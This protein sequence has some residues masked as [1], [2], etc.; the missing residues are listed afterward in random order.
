MVTLLSPSTWYDDYNY[1]L[2]YLA[3]SE[4]EWRNDI[5]D[6]LKFENAHVQIADAKKSEWIY[7]YHKFIEYEKWKVS[8]LDSAELVIF[9]FDKDTDHNVLIELGLC[10]KMKG[11]DKDV[12]V[13]CS[14]D[15]KYYGNVVV[16]CEEFRIFVHT[17]DMEEIETWLCSA[18]G[19]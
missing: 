14:P 17:K 10:C 4:G 9:Y 15:Y 16:M 13:Y 1:P 19:R 6:Q 5:I 7:P 12:M 18:Y 11:V 2:I 3:G 8:M